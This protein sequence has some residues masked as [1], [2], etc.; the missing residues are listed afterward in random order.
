MKTPDEIKT[1]L[2][3]HGWTLCDNDCPY[4]DWKGTG[5]DCSNQLCMDSHTYIEQLER[6]RDAAVADLKLAR[7][8]RTCKNFAKEPGEK[9]CS[10][11][12]IAGRNYEW[13]G[14]KEEKTN[15]D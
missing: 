1:G 10:N 11:C 2:S 12:G 6:E 4:S 8:C 3:Y 9:P 15:E 14:V 5:Y 13:R 7:N